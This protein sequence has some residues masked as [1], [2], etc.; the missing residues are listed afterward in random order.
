LR[1]L[2]HYLSFND[3]SSAAQIIRIL[4]AGKKA[5]FWVLKAVLFKNAV[6]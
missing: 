5:M 6:S 3:A 2:I 1:L 4:V